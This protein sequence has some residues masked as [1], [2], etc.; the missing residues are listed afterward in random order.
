MKLSRCIEVKM[1]TGKIG[2]FDQRSNIFLR[3]EKIISYKIIN[4][5]T[6]IKNPKIV[7]GDMLARYN[8]LYF[9]L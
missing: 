7:D 9:T 8:L 3:R 4:G 5:K 6:K 2:R 1:Y